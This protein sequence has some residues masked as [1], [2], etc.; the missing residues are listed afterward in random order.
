MA[1]ARPRARPSV[2]LARGLVL[3][4]RAAPTRARLIRGTLSVAL[5]VRVHVQRLGIAHRARDATHSALSRPRHDRL[6]PILCALITL[7]IL[8]R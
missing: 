2:P 5:L 1:P 7:F 8:I 3:G 6:P 4:Q